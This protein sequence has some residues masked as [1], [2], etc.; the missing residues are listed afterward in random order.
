MLSKYATTGLQE[1]LLMKIQKNEKNYFCLL[2]LSSKPQL[3]WFGMV[4]FQW[5]TGDC[6]KVCAARAAR[7]FLGVQPIEF[8]IWG[9]AMAVDVV[10][11]NAMTE[12]QLRQ[13]EILKSAYFN[14]EIY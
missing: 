3:W 1:A 10:N 7:L 14:N 2:K 4:S 8:V 9:I 13:R 6:S 11:A 5:K 12:W